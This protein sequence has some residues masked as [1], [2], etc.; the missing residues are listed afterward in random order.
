MPDSA[1]SAIL[2]R[3]T[4]RGVWLEQYPLPGGG[5]LLVPL[6][7]QWSLWA[8]RLADT[9]FWDEPSSNDAGRP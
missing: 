2:S 3:R 4:R 5:H 8:E 1:N 7:E 6:V 9:A